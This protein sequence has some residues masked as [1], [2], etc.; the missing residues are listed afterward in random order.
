MGAA[1]QHR[2]SDCARVLAEDFPD[3]LTVEQL[4]LSVCTCLMHPDRITRL[5]AFRLIALYCATTEARI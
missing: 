5:H 2:A 4:A 1:L 3:R